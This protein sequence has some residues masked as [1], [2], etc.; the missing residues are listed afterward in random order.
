MV[1]ENKV[2]VNDQKLGDN[3]FKKVEKI[4]PNKIKRCQR[5]VGMFLD[6]KDREMIEKSLSDN[7]LFNTMVEGATIC[8]E[9]HKKRR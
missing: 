4:L 5:I 1:S 6:Y 7:K 2:D 9:K 3:L 8:L